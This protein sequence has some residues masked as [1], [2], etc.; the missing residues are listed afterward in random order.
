[1]TCTGAAA[2][3]FKWLLVVPF[4]GPVMSGV[5]RLTVDGNCEMQDRK[6]RTEIH[7]AIANYMNIFQ[8][9]QDDLNKAGELILE[10]ASNFRLRTY[11]R[12][13]FAF[14]E[15][16]IF[17]IKQLALQMHHHHPCFSE[18][19]V[20]LLEEVTYELTSNGAVQTRVKHLETLSN[21]KF[22]L[23]AIVKAFDL[24]AN[25]TFDESGWQRFRESI[26]IRH[27]ITHPKSKASLT[28]SDDDDGQGIKVDTIMEASDWYGNAISLLCAELMRL[29]R[30]R[31]I[32]EGS[33][34]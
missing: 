16:T 23:K 13:F 33:E 28:I 29:I 26:K 24:K 34:K 15:G 2:A 5:R 21:I 11:T 18:A 27:D 12:T 3:R 10:D 14:V 9:L 1:M 17:G 8:I 20:N 6:K 32:E 19:E 7:Q 30:T 4:G 22:T 25:I 31:Y